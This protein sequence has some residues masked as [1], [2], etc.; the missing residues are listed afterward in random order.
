MNYGIQNGVGGLKIIDRE[1]VLKMEPHLNKEV[2][3][4]LYCK[5]AGV[6]LTL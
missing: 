6:M 4:A 5:D 1:E 3:W 2:K